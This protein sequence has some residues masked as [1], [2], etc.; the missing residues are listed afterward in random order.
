MKPEAKAAQQ[1]RELA[2]SLETLDHMQLFELVQ[3]LLT[4]KTQLDIGE[5]TRE[6]SMTLIRLIGEWI[7]KPENKR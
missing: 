3:A 7:C 2:K 1:T 6:L 4:I 5:R